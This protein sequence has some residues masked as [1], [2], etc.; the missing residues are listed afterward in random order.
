MFVLTILDLG[1]VS[2]SF[3]LMISNKSVYKLN[4]LV[5][6]GFGV[7]IVQNAIFQIFFQYMK[8]QNGEKEGIV[9]SP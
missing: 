6:K 5:R 9:P 7:G 8:S 2:H 1:I 3:S 4:D